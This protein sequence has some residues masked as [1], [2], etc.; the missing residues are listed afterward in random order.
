MILRTLIDKRLSEGKPL[1]LIF[2]DYSAAFDS[3][4]HKFLD[5]ALGEANARPKTRAIFRSIYGSA[6]AKTRVKS[7]D[8]EHVFSE[9]FPV[10]RGV[11]QGDIT[12]PLYFIIALEAIL[13]RYDN[14]PGKG[15]P[16]GEARLH[17]LG[18]ADDAALIDESTSTASNRVSSIAAGSK[19]AA[20]MEINI[21]KTECMHVKRQ[22]RVATPIQAEAEKV[23]EHK[24]N[25]PGCGWIFGNKHGLKIHKEKWC[26]WRRYYEVERILDHKCDQLP[27]GLGKTQFLIKWRGYNHTYNEWVPYE[28]VTK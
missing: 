28:N 15:V 4:S 13:R 17:T 16:F 27:V 18:Y 11:I 25:N 14:T 21:S 10:R 2:I 3:V 1:V 5:Q 20:D 8:G 6:A 24:C 7:I 12:S 23:C 9:T 19:D 26:E 22:Q